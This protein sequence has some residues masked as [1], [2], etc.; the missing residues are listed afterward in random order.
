MSNAMDLDEFLNAQSAGFTA[1]LEAVPDNPTHVKVTPHRDGGGCGCGSSFELPRE[2]VRSV[3]GTGTFHF[4]CGKRLQIAV[5]EFAEDASIPVADLMSR[6]AHG[7]AHEHPH[8]HAHEHAHEHAHAH[9]H[10]HEP[11]ER[12][13]TPHDHPHAHPPHDAAARQRPF[14]DGG[15]IRVPPQVAARGGRGLVGRWPIPSF[16]CDLVCIEVCTGFC[17][18]TGWDCCQWETRCGFNC[19]GIA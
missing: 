18:P 10:P 11:F 5:V 17:G 12:E 9:G 13:R 8:G 4:C 7:H 14:A 19:Y 6:P 15:S 2:M 3:T 1:T 16:P